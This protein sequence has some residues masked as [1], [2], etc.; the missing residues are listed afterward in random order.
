MQPVPG[1]EQ[2][3][4]EGHAGVPGREHEPVP[5]QPLLVRRIVDQHIIR[6]RLTNAMPLSPAVG[7]MAGAASIT[8]GYLVAISPAGPADGEARS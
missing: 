6:P 5:A 8:S 7:P 4:V 3:D 2:L 1:Q